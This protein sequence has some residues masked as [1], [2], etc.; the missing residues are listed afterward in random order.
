M[1]SKPTSAYQRS[2][3]SAIGAYVLWGILPVY[4]K[5]LEQVPAWEILSHRIIWSFVFLVF[6]LACTRRLGAFYADTK[7]LFSQPQKALG[8]LTASLLVSLNWLLYIWSVNNGRIVEASL[9]YYI[10]PLVNVVLGILFLKERLSRAQIASLLL[11]AAGVLYLAL[12]FGSL[13]WVALALAILFGLYGLCKKLLNISAVTGITLETLLIT[14]IALFFL[15][16]W[17]NSG[18]PVFHSE[19]PFAA[20]LLIASGVITA[21]PLLLFTSGANG[22]PLSVLGFI[23]FLSPTISLLVGV[24]AYHETFSSVHLVSFSLIW[25]ALILFL[26]SQTAKFSQLQSSLRQ[27]LRQGARSL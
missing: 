10:N 12:H 22:L 17:H 14:P 19:Q 18:I 27:K 6:L 9:G 1:S 2:F 16:F 20:A 25:L 4:W 13:P 24:L 15:I 26:A 3:A 7:A 11:A 8:I 23:Q 5:L 21:I